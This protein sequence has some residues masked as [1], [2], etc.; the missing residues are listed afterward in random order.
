[1]ASASAA[2]PAFY[3]G[4]MKPLFGLD[5]ATRQLAASL[6]PSGI[7]PHFGGQQMHSEPERRAKPC[8]TST[9]G[10]N[11]PTT[12]P[13]PSCST[14]ASPVPEE[15]GRPQGGMQITVPATAPQATPMA[16]EYPFV[17]GGPARGLDALRAANIARGG[18]LSEAAA[19]F[20]GASG[21]S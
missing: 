18:P 17:P 16:G 4:D 13:K 6:D 14:T 3:P 7:P 20:A 2:N 19:M 15:L 5:D 8:P 12:W 1:M 11:F 9:A 10:G 21:N